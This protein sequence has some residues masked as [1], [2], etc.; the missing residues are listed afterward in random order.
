M[1]VIW[2][3][4]VVSVAITI[5]CLGVFVVQIVLTASD[6]HRWITDAGRRSAS[7]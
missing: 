2:F 3:W 1:I 5:V 7:R 4:I 6:I